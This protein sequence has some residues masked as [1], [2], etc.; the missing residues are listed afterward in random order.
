[1]C[2]AGLIVY[3]T[4]LHEKENKLTITRL[5]ATTYG[6]RIKQEISDGIEITHTLQQLLIDENWTINKFDTIANNLVNDSVESIQL[7]PNGV[8]TDIYPEEENEAGKIDLLNDKERG[9]ISCYARD[10]H[11]LITRGPF[12]LKQ[13]G[14]GIAV[15]NPV[16]LEDGTGQEYF[17]GFTIIILRV[18]DIFSESLSAVSEFGYEYRLSKTVA[19][20]DDTY[21]IDSQSDDKLTSPIS[22]GFTIG[23]ENWKFELMPK[24]GWG[25][26]VCNS[27]WRNS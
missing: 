11:I 22:Y 7:A 24:G 9:K 15:R 26:K 2:L 4:N 13:G 20:W 18:P 25:K 14:E 27:A 17:W 10:D 1:M 12:E 8:V 5:N 21:E 3:K 19:P 16:Y 23:E 6:E